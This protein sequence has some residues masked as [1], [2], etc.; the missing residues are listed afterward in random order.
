M[1]SPG[2]PAGTPARA[3]GR[4]PP[5]AGQQVCVDAAG[6]AAGLHLLRLGARWRGVPLAGRGRLRPGVCALGWR[7]VSDER[8]GAGVLKAVSQAAYPPWNP[9]RLSVFRDGALDPGPGKG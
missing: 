9:Q 1:R 4:V 5:A 7:E 8:D 3:A 6:S 2:A